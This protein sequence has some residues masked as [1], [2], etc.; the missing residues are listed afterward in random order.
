[1]NYKVRYAVLDPH[2]IFNYNAPTEGMIKT[3]NARD[4]FYAQLEAS[5]LKEGIRNPIS[6]VSG[7]HQQGNILERFPEHLRDSNILYCRDSGC[8]R[9]WVAQKNNIDIP[10]LIADGNDRFSDQILL[11]TKEEVLKFYADEPTYV[12]FASDRI[13]IAKKR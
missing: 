5:I 1:M 8:S 11:N 10:C 6:V 2:L 4:G 3:H 12:K 13:I 9:L 7:F